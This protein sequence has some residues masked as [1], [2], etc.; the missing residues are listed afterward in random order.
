MSRLRILAV[1]VAFAVGAACASSTAAPLRLYTTVTQETVDAVVDAYETDSGNTVDVLR[2]PTGELNARIATEL[3]SG[4]LRADILWLT[5]PLSL[6]RYEADGLLSVWNPA[7]SERIDPSYTTPSS[8]GTRVLNLVIVVGDSVTDPPRSWS[9]LARM[10]GPVAIPDPGFAG[11]AFAALAYFAL[12]D[13][14]EF[15]SRLADDAAVQVQSPGEVVTGVAEG[16]FAAGITLDFAAKAAVA[17]GSPIT[18]VWP[19]PGAIA[20]HSPIAVAATSTRDDAAREFVEFVLSDRGQ[21][22]I[23]AAGWQPAVAGVGEQTVPGP[24]VT[25]DWARAADRQ[26]ELLSEYRRLFGG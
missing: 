6:Q 24:Q 11:S 10:E 2:V 8:W 21:A 7:G 23:A 26:D 4:G 19:E 5:D 13:G 18:L 17:A 12:N 9:D 3:R 25:V 1:V 15:Y 16:R 20:F 14:F 22:A